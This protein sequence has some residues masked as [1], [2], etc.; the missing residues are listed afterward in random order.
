MMKACLN[1]LLAGLVLIFAFSLTGCKSE[2]GGTVV[3]A[4]LVA[5]TYDEGCAICHD[6]GKVADVVTVHSNAIATDSPFVSILAVRQVLVAGNPRLEVDFRMVENT[7]RLVP[8]YIDVTDSTDYRNVRFTLAKLMPG[9]AAGDSSFWVSYIYS[10]SSGNATYERGDAGT[11]SASAS[12]LDGE[13]TYQYSF[14]MDGVTDPAT[15]ALIT[16]DV[17]SAHRIAI[18]YSGNVDNATQ[19]FLPNT[20][21]EGPVFT[22]VAVSRDIVLSASCNECHV[23]LAMHGSDRVNVDYCVTCHSPGGTPDADFKVM[24]H[25]LHRGSELPSVL[26]GATYEVGGHDYGGTAGTGVGGIVFPQDIRNCTKCH[27]GA[28]LS[29]N[30]KDVPNKEACGSCHDD[31]NFTTGANHVGGAATNA[32]C[33]G[34][35]PAAGTVAA[36]TETHVIPEQVAALSFLYTIVSVT[37][38]APGEFPVVTFSVTDPTAAGA[39]YDI[40]N[41]PEFQPGGGAHS[42]SVLLGWNNDDYTNTDSTSTPAQPVRI[43]ALSGAVDNLDGTFTVA[44]T[45]SIPDLTT[46]SGTV[47]IEGHP[48]VETVA[49]SGTY[50]LRVP[51]L[52]AVQSFTITDVAASDRRTVVSAT[53][54]CNNCHENL[55]LHGSNRNN[56]TQLCVIC[57]N[58]NATDISVRPVGGLGADGKAEEAID[59]KYMIHAIHGGESSQHGF[60]TAGI[61]VYGYGGSLHDYS[62][63]RMPDSTL[64]LKNCGGCHTST[65]RFPNATALPTTVKTGSDVAEPNDD[66]NYTPVASACSS[67]HDGIAS[68][69]H[70]AQYGGLFD[71]RAFVDTS[72]GNSGGPSGTQPAGHSSRTD[73]TSCHSSQ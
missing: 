42:L 35:H 63:V 49:G 43:N 55:N 14:D 40:N 5:Q 22:A 60:R 13:Y 65:I 45:V 41:D 3:A 57:H 39:A 66:T 20:L 16:Y 71:F 1:Y 38:T 34:C 10:G 21:P 6:S 73:C 62:H 25:K 30:W 23:R 18:Q 68:K 56:N 11:F 46:G 19:D 15:A 72:G 36:V 54:R 2:S 47:A 4:N 61:Q 52:G 48:A 12:G 58:A 7:N 37:N 24:I 27:T 28:T 9:A 32:Q 51:V 64:N 59:F 69:T 31:L 44:S 8:V 29:D 53:T 70:I 50:D 26:S 33:A 17:A 67:C